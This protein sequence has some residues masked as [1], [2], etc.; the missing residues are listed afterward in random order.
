MTDAKWSLQASLP[1]N[2]SGPQQLICPFQLV[3]VRATIH[4]RYDSLVP[5]W[6]GTIK[7][8]G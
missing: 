6:A 7:L 4:R 3:S 1:Q 8:D 2:D 5:L